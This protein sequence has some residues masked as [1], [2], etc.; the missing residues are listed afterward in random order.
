MFK[1]VLDDLTVCTK[2]LVISEVVHCPTA[3]FAD[4]GVHPYLLVATDCPSLATRSPQYPKAREALDCPTTRDLAAYIGVPVRF[5]ARAFPP[6]SLL[7]LMLC[8]D[9]VCWGAVDPR[10]RP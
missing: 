4:T 10:R 1:W 2:Q 5:T 8:K 6:V 7:T 3:A 9:V